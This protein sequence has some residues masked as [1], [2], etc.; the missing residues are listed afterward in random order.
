MTVR[1]SVWGGK[2]KKVAKAKLRM[3][4]ALIP[5]AGNQICDVDMHLSGPCVEW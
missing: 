2:E 3:F 4:Y 1:W 5:S